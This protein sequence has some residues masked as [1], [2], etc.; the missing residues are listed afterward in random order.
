GPH[1]AQGFEHAGGLAH[2]AAGGSGRLLDIL[3][4]QHRGRRARADRG[5]DPV[6][7]LLEQADHRRATPFFTG[8]MTSSLMH[9]EG[10]DVATNSTASA[11]S[12]AV[13]MWL[14]ASASGT[15]GRIA[16]KSLS[17]SPGQ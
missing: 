7:H 13:I 2:H 8:V 15:F 1:H 10:G 11:T 6:E 5:A 9:T 12:S 14:R 4:R 16:R 17:T 3:C